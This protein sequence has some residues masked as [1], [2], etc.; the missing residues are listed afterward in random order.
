[1]RFHVVRSRVMRLPVFRASRAGPP[2]GAA[3][4]GDASAVVP[5][6]PPLP[7]PLPPPPLAS[8]EWGIGHPTVESQRAGLEH[9]TRITLEQAA[10]R[11]RRP[12][13]D[14]GSIPAQL[15]TLRV[16]LHHPG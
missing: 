13:Q 10:A 4:G 16:I 2:S 14:I 1:M 15:A 5:P 11:R 12:G 3:S 8:G 6:P 9:L 7:P